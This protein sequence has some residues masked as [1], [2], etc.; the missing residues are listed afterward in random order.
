MLLPWLSIL[1]RALPYIAIIGAALGLVLYVNNLRSTVR[2]QATQIDG[3]KVAIAAESLAR[4]K[5]VAGLTA[6][7]SGLA[8]AAVDNAKDRAAMER[9]ID[10]A[11]PKPT[12]PGLVS[13]IACLRAKGGD[14]SK[15][16]PASTG[17]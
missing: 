9:T 17:I 6:L 14:G 10:V 12:S 11:N 16:A 5:D 7:S 2:N 4:R 13:L 1:R 3:L 15:C 8:S